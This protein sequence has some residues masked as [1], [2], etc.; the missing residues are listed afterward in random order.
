MKHKADIIN[1]IKKNLPLVGLVVLLVSIVI[2]VFIQSENQKETIALS[3]KKDSITHTQSITVTPSIKPSPSPTQ[4]PRQAYIPDPDDLQDIPEI[5]ELELIENQI[6][7]TEKISLKWDMNEDADYYLLCILDDDGNIMQKE[8]LW[9]NIT[10]WEIEDFSGSSV[11]LLS[12]KDMG[13][14]NAEDDILIASYIVKI[15]SDKDQLT[16]NETGILPENKYHILID[17][18]DF[19]LAILTYDENL[20]Y[21]KVVAVFPCALGRSSRMTPTGKFTISNKGDWKTWKTGEYS[22]YYTRYT[23]GL[24][25]HGSLYSKKSYSTLIADYYERIGSKHTS[26]CIRTTLEGARWIYYNCPSG[27]VVEIVESSDLISYPG[28]LD[29]DPDFPTWDPTDPAKPSS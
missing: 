21:N 27:T 4:T 15:K 23:S 25:I 26:G 10:E 19:T 20:E 24:Y 29:I 3:L 13:E 28:K 16:L 17:K 9:A 2:I 22:P 1:H 5:G 18:E 14:D 11:L 6:K 12:Y 7:S 8:I